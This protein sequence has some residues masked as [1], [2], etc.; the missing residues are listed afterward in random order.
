MSH[1]MKSQCIMIAILAV[2]LSLL[3]FETW[4]MVVTLTLLAGVFG[5][6][7][8]LE[9]RKISASEEIDKRVQKLEER[10]NNLTLRGLK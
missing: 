1:K 2:L 10:L 3:W 8:W 9:G 6:T 7:E 4:E 5:F